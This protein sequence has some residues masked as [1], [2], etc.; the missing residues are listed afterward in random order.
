M[1]KNSSFSSFNL[2]VSEKR[3]IFASQIQKVCCPLM[4]W[5]QCLRELNIFFFKH[6]NELSVKI[7]HYFFVHFLPIGFANVNFKGILNL[8]F[9]LSNVF[10]PLQ[11]YKYRRMQ[12]SVWKRKGIWILTKSGTIISQKLIKVLNL[13]IY[14]FF[15]LYLKK[16]SYLCLR[17]K[18]KI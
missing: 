3:R 6:C 12:R 11:N 5:L 13:K 18:E 15:C 17:L 9:C 10:V 7:A 4:H 2:L 1:L 8:C 14:S 16:N